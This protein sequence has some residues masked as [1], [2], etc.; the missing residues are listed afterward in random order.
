MR[1]SVNIVSRNPHA[2]Q[3]CKAMA[4]GIG[5]CGDKAVVR[6]DSDNVMA[7]FDAAV[8]WGYIETCQQA[9]RNCQKLGI[10]WVFID[11]GYWRREQGYFK[12][13][14]NDRHPT[15]YLM[16]LPHPTRRFEKLGLEIK[17][18]K[19]NISGSILVA[20]M[21]HK[22]AWSWGLKNEQYET[23]VI[24]KLRADYPDYPVIYRP[25]PNWFGS[26]KIYGATFDK[27]SRLKN[28][29]PNLWCVVSHHSNVCCEALLEG[30]PVFCMYGA[31]SL[32]GEHDLT[33]IIK[34]ARPEGR[35]Q[36]A[37]NLAYCQWTVPEMA[38]G[39]C[40]AY[41]KEVGLVQ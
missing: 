27:S 37:A 15:N 23:A 33:K 38:E 12:V 24:N 5:R 8:L 10:P 9:I 39:K 25:K 31:A 34:P 7:G 6:S 19:V 26:T 17:P 18:W 11:M 16:K 4:Q 3:T 28:L 41:L 20:G 1:V 29:W 14:V 2:H 32:L 21:S 36:W 13:T 30:I 40:W 35:E 22:A